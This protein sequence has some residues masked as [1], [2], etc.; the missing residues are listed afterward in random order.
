MVQLLLLI[1]QLFGAISLFIIAMKLVSDSLQALSGDRLQYTINKLT[2]NNFTA[3][4]TGTIFTT[5]IQS[6]SASSVFFLSFV[7]A[8]LI[9]LRKAFA[10]IIGANIGTTITLWLIVAGLQF[11]LLYIALPLLIVAVPLYISQFRNRRLIGTIFIGFSMLFFALFLMKSFLPDFTQIDLLQKYIS[12]Y[13]DFT[14]FSAI[15][16]L[17]IGLVL[18]ICIHFSSATIAISLILVSKGLPMELAA[19]MILGANI[20]TTFTTQI[21]SFVGNQSTRMVANFHTFFNVCSAIIFLFF[22]PYIIQFLENFISNPNILLIGFDT[23]T[24]IVMGVIFLLILNPLCDFIIQ[25][26]NLSEDKNIKNLNFINIPFGN[27]PNLYLNDANRSILRLATVTRQSIQ[28]LGR[29]IT[30]SDEEKFKVLKHR[31]LELENESDE[32]ETEITD[33]LM[34]I[35]DLEINHTKANH[36]QQLLNIC[37]HLENIG[38]IAIKMTIIHNKRRKSNSFITPNLRLHLSHLQQELN[39]ATTILIQHLSSSNQEIDL[40]KS[41]Q[42]ECNINAMYKNAEN[43]LI[44]I[45]E[46]GK[47]PTLSALYYKELIQNYELIGDHIYKANKALIKR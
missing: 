1:L 20:G 16:F 33:Y 11:N 47:L 4:L 32:I 40:E 46:K 3:F 43:D 41:K 24:N 5:S 44:K 6:S 2:K 42:I 27:N 30:E 25:K 29:M 14:F 15:L 19:A 34:K 23:I 26:V 35:Y 7:N 17:I 8:G 37:H 22:I 39:L 13:Q 21:A 9:N 18:T 45:I 10:L 12:Q 31:I 36:I 28:T 38:D